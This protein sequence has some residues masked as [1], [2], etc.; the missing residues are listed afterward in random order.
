MLHDGFV[1]ASPGLNRDV[2]PT[3]KALFYFGKKVFD[4]LYY[5]IYI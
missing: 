5:C 3:V 2:Q 1:P 4:L